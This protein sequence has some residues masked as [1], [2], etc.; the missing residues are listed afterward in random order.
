MLLDVL[1]PYEDL[2]RSIRIDCFRRLGTAHE[3]RATIIL[4]DGS[5]LHIRDYVFIDGT[6]KYSYHWQSAAGRLRRRWDN[7]GH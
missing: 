5:Q 3:L 4:V 1:V 7:S 6:R 2:I